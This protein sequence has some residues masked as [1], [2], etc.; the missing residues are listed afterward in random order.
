MIEC[1]HRLLQI[2]LCPGM[3]LLTWHRSPLTY[4]QWDIQFQN[5]SSMEHMTTKNLHRH[6]QYTLVTPPQPRLFHRCHNHLP[7]IDSKRSSTQTSL[8]FRTLTTQSIM[9]I[10]PTNLLKSRS[11][12]KPTATRLIIWTRQCTHISTGTIS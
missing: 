5:W 2:D 7:I 11:N 4:H 3:Y 6:L 1:N 12:P 8:S 9:A 10:P